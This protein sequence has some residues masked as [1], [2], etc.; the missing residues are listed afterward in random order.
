MPLPAGHKLG[1]Y[2]ILEPLGEGGM[3]E[4]Y[5]ARDTRLSRSVAIK[6]SRSEFTERF[7]VEARAVAQLNHPHICQLYDVGP[8]YL[9]MEFVD[10]KELRG[11]LPLDKAILYA[12]QILDALHAAHR[13]RITHRDL[14]PANIIVTERGIKLL[15]FGL[16]KL[17]APLEATDAT[18]ATPTMQGQI[19]GTLQYMSPEQLQGKPVDARSDIFSFGCV[20]YELLTGSRAFDGESAA[21]VIAAIIEREPQPAGISSPL[22]RIITTCLAK[23][24][25]Q[26]FQDVLDL[27]RNLVWAVEDK[28]PAGEL[29]RKKVPVWAIATIALLA[30]AVA[31]SIFFQRPHR[32]PPP[33]LTR[34]TR[35]GVSFA[36]ALSLDG[37]MLAFASSRIDSNVDVYI[38]Q[39]NS[40]VPLR[41]TD[42]PA[43]DT[44]PQFTPD[45][46][47]IVFTSYRQPVGTYEVSTLGGEARLLIPDAVN[48]LPSPTGRHIVYARRGVLMLDTLPPS[49]PVEIAKSPELGY[50]WSPDGEEIIA[51]QQGFFRFSVNTRQR[52]EIG[53]EQ[54]LRRLNMHVVQRTLP[55]QWLP[56]GE[57]LFTASSGDANNLW[58]IPLSDASRAAPVPVTIGAF[59]GQTYAAAA[60]GKLAFVDNASASALWTLACDLNAG[61]VTGA[62]V[63]VLPDKADG[64]H[65]DISPDGSTLVYASRKTG[66]QSLFVRDL[67]T[68]KERLLAAPLQPGDAF[69]HSRFSPDGKRVVAA[70]SSLDKG[71]TPAGW[72]L[73]VMPTAG[74]EMNTVYPEGARIRGWTPD[75]NLLLLWSSTPPQRIYVLDLSSRERTDL[76]PFAPDRQFAQPSLS[77]DGK[78]IAFTGPPGK[79]LYIAPFRGAQAVHEAEWIVVA[80]V[81]D[82]PFWSPDGRQLYFSTS[83]SV[84][85]ILDREDQLT[86]YRRPLDTANKRPIGDPVAFY[87]FSGGVFG[88]AVVNPIAVARD[89]IVFVFSVRDS[90][91]WMMDLPTR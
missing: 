49:G 36:P 19:V 8:N 44:S 28:T 79:R 5:K 58:R 21:S 9:V 33:R 6:I 17:G 16:A 88:V 7:E 84:G 76:F 35:D 10:G 14:K 4:V 11:P 43:I 86:V 1:P 55:V 64:A 38:Q 47:R 77:P 74:G 2:E 22:E 39:P 72:K 30:V 90:D 18:L 31:A 71:G 67:R 24:P 32:E 53:L 81:A 34:L 57:L 82:H 52:T 63:R 69:A 83:N 60:V 40:T 78:W 85:S 75:G 62:P 87:T 68:H 23:D 89:R 3:G 65:P 91:I 48:A 42:D 37:K 46:S 54:T 15:D 25:E 29:V 45:G 12:T 26:R 70:Y 56:S 73:V 66:Q 59:F 13:R 20:L 50:V 80:D 61:K 27:K 41:I 51:N